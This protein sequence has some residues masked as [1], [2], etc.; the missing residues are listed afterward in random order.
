MCTIATC[1]KCMKN[2]AENIHVHV[3]LYSRLKQETRKVVNEPS[4]S[5]KFVNNIQIQAKSM[6]Q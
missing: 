2:S 1:S 3:R 4:S 5:K 6:E